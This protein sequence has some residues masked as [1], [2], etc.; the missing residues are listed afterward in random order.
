MAVSYA[1]WIQALP[2]LHHISAE[3]ARIPSPIAYPTSEDVLSGLDLKI[4]IMC[5]ANSLRWTAAE[6]IVKCAGIGIDHALSCIGHT[7]P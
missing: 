2:S 5:P 1:P 6:P 3:Y 7:I 4:L